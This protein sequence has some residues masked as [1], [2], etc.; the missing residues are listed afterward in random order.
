MN[1]DIL[2]GLKKQIMKYEIPN[3]YATKPYMKIMF[4]IIVEKVDMSSDEISGEKKFW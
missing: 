4:K 3:I 1:L 2:T